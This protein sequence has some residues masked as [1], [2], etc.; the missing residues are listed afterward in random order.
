MSAFT[1]H[2]SL[3][4]QVTKPARHHHPQSNGSM[5]SESTLTYNSTRSGRQSS[6][7]SLSPP[8]SP[9]HGVQMWRRFASRHVPDVAEDLVQ[10]NTLTPDMVPRFNTLMRHLKNNSEWDEQQKQVMVSQ[11]DALV[12]EEFEE[13]LRGEF[14][15]RCAFGD[16]TNT[17]MMSS[18]KWVKFLRNCGVVPGPDDKRGKPGTISVAEVD[19]IFLKVLHHC[20]YGGKRLTYELFCKALYLVACA[21]RP[22]LGERA[23]SELLGRVA[24]AVPEEFRV[25]APD[26]MLDANVLL[27]LDPFKPALRDLFHS[28]CGR[29]LPSSTAGTFGTGTVRIRE[30]TV[31]KSSL[32]QEGTANLSFS[33]PINPMDS[34]FSQQAHEGNEA[35]DEVHDGDRFQN[36]GKDSMDVPERAR[37]APTPYAVD[38]DTKA[39]D[40]DGSERMSLSTAARSSAAHSVAKE[41]ESGFFGQ[42]RSFE[43]FGRSFSSASL[44]GGH[45]MMSSTYS[46]ATVGHSE[47]ED[48][49]LYANGA[50]V[51]KN[52]LRHMSLDQLMIMCRDLNIL[53]DL[54]TRLEVVQIFKRA[55]CAGSGSVHGSSKYAYL[56]VETFVDAVGQLALA[57]YSKPPFSEGNPEPHEKIFGFFTAVL[58]NAQALHGRYR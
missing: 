23:F 42:P 45:S 5:H 38:G 1:A 49:Y 2:P 24:A 40:A 13:I 53:P 47:H 50:P 10:S 9:G 22:D 36:F 44:R 28:F 34:V 17:E 51:I 26:L 37:P 16:R 56:N 31:W 21:V 19:V 58:P 25:E 3:Q 15:R 30:R 4:T 39:P 27:V 11:V 12:P 33:L 57:A 20:D 35:G 14:E 41:Q 18:P 55:Q 54:V 29:N 52:R 48:P 6:L 8:Q 46:L 7:S 43:R 32:T